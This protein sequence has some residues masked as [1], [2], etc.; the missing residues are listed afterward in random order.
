MFRN[1]QET[2][3]YI[4]VGIVA[5]ALLVLALLELAKISAS[6]KRPISRKRKTGG[7]VR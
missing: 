3:S 1:E 7:N 6:L 2:M 4:W 5:G